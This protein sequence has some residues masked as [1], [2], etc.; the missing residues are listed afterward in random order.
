M[1][2]PLDILATKLGMKKIMGCTFDFLGCQTQ[3]EEDPCDFFFGFSCYQTQISPGLGCGGS[4]SRSDLWVW[5]DSVA[6][7]VVFFFPCCCLWLRWI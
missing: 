4:R 2:C 7:V 6:L 5:V 1:D 3:N